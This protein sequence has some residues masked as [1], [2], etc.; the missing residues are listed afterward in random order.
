[1]R[2]KVK[3][4][5]GDLLVC[6]EGLACSQTADL[7]FFNYTDEETGCLKI[8]MQLEVNITYEQQVCSV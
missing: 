3:R 8:E 7:D 5:V 1:M 4:L 6:F 2:E